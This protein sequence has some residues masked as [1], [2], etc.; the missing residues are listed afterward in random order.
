MI[1]TYEWHSR[2]IISSIDQCIDQTYDQHR[3]DEYIAETKSLF[4]AIANTE[5]QQEVLE[6]AV[7]ASEEEETGCEFL[8]EAHRLLM[9]ENGEMVHRWL[10]QK[11]L[12]EGQW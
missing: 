11:L 9:I 6:R 1:E 10:W 7:R 4:R 5:E 3:V 8:K 2:S 12:N